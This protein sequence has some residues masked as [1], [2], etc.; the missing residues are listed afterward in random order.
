MMLNLHQNGILEIDGSS[1]KYIYNKS[2]KL[3]FAF[4][5]YCSSQ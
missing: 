4:G 1:V 2:R 3:H 5:I